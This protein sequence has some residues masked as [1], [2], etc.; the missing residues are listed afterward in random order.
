VTPKARKPGKDA[1]QRG[2]HV[3]LLP[4]QPDGAAPGRKPRDQCRNLGQRE[5]LVQIGG[6]VGMRAVQDVAAADM[7]RGRSGRDRDRTGEAHCRADRCG[8]AE[9]VEERGIGLVRRQG[10]G[11]MAQR[12]KARRPVEMD[13][14][15]APA[16]RD[17]GGKGRGIGRDRVDVRD[18]G[19]AGRLGQAVAGKTGRG[20]QRPG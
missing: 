10:R 3:G 1:R 11:A 6:H 20:E 9:R 16:C 12:R 5:R 4:D 14:A 2:L 15:R 18:I 7:D 17:A 8:K 19:T 13:Q